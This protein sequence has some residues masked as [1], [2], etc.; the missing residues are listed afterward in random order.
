MGAKGSFLGLTFLARGQAL[1]M[2][3]IVV[4]RF[5]GVLSAYGIH[6]ADIVIEKQE[7]SAT[8]Y[9][10]SSL[11]GLLARI[12]AL[13]ASG[14]QE[15]QDQAFDPS[16]IEV[17]RFMN[18][19]FAGTDCALMTSLPHGTKGQGGDYSK[20]LDIHIPY[21]ICMTWPVE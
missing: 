6:L 7:P 11:P 10:P 19:R 5:S 9:S 13:E 2:R 17:E 21:M 1:G 8:T 18:L 12:D 16:A 4:S 14:R 3:R 15:L 20:V